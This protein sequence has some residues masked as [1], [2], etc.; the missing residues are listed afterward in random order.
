MGK[1]PVDTWNTFVTSLAHTERVWEEHRKVMQDQVEVARLLPPTVSR[2][3]LLPFWRSPFNK[4][5]DRFI[6][7][8]RGRDFLSLKVE[9]PERAIDKAQEEKKNVQKKRAVAE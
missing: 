6:S 1:N 9:Q 2:M 4:M 3:L 8:F 7:Q 5:I